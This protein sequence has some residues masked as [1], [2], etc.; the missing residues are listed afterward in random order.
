MFK[1]IPVPFHLCSSSR[2]QISLEHFWE[3]AGKW[4]QI[5]GYRKEGGAYQ[6]LPA[7]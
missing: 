2:V 3:V 1:A 7:F 4:A 6:G 5:H